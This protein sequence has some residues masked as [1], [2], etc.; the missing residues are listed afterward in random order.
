MSDRT[1]RIVIAA[2]TA[3]SALAFAFGLSGAVAMTAFVVFTVFCPGIAW[4]RLLG[5]SD[6]GDQVAIGVA[7]GV[8]IAVIVAETM[9]LASWWSPGTGFAVL[10]GITAVGLAFSPSSAHGTSAHETSA[11]G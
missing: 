6:R 1:L 4:A 5:I 8:A 2:W 3:L 7:L 10:A 9:A 11:H